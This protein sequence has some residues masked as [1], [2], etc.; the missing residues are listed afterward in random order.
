MWPRTAR[1]RRT[2]RAM[3]CT[4]QRAFRTASGQLVHSFQRHQIN[5]DRTWY[6]SAAGLADLI[7]NLVETVTAS[8]SC[9]SLFFARHSYMQQPCSRRFYQLQET[10]HTQSFISPHT[11]ST[12]IIIIKILSKIQKYR[13]VM[14]IGQSRKVASEELYTKTRM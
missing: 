4:L 7:D 14:R 1:Q 9:L 5:R 10:L 13:Q 2:M 6:A 12:W 11:S 8:Q 3:Q